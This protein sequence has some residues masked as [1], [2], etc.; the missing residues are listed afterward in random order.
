VAQKGLGGDMRPYEV[1]IYEGDIPLPF[2]A[3]PSVVTHPHSK[4]RILFL[5][6]DDQGTGLYRLRYSTE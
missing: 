2:D 4:R 5:F 3:D 1:W 6:V